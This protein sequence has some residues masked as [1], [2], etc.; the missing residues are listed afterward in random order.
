VHH[1]KRP[2][3]LLVTFLAVSVLA[4]LFA[5]PA[6]SWSQE[7][8]NQFCWVERAL[9]S[10]VVIVGFASLIIGGWRMQGVDGRLAARVDW[11]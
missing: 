11:S 9:V 3:V 8:C 10:T 4:T 6:Y 7:E 2:L 5:L 1:I